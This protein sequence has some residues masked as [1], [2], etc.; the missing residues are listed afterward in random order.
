MLGD[1]VLAATVSTCAEHQ[2][3]PLM[4]D[5][6]RFLRTRWTPWAE[7]KDGGRPS[8]APGSH[9]APTAATTL[10]RGRPL[11]N[12]LRKLLPSL[13]R[14]VPKGPGTAAFHGPVLGD[15]S[16]NMLQAKWLRRSPGDRSGSS[17]INGMEEGLRQQGNS[18]TW[19]GRSSSTPSRAATVGD[20]WA[21]LLPHRAARLTDG[22]PHSTQA[23]NHSPTSLTP[24]PAA[25]PRR[26]WGTAQMLPRTP[27]RFRTSAARQRGTR[28]SGSNPP[29]WPAGR[30]E[31][32]GQQRPARTSIARSGS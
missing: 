29:T 3:L 27:S 14:L 4:L 30:A 24:G 6:D 20:G 25:A 22:G 10:R 28:W 11:T 23:K 21:G 26:R 12:K 8:S 19:L 1:G 13:D 31:V 16:S 7:C 32:Q 17:Y 9:Q 5:C 2:A 18:A 15:D